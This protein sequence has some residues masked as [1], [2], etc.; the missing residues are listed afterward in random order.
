MAAYRSGRSGACSAA[1]HD[2]STCLI[3]DVTRTHTYVLTGVLTHDSSNAAARFRNDSR[4]LFLFSWRG[5][6]AD[7]V[8]PAPVFTAL[9]PRRRCSNSVRLFVTGRP[10]LI[11]ASEALLSPASCATAAPWMAARQAISAARE[12]LHRRPG[13]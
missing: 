9:A 1:G 4:V 13:I 7:W 12:W 3:E 5:S 10:T 11:A 6:P 2:R 8:W